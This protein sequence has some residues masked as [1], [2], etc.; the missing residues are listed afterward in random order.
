MRDRHAGGGGVV[1]EATTRP[2]AATCPQA[3]WL[4]QP[5][6]PPVHVDVSFDIPAGGMCAFVGPCGAGKTTVFSLIERFYE[7]ASG[8]VLVDGMD[9]L[10]WAITDLRAAIGYVEQDAPVLSGTLRENLLFGSPDPSDGEL[11][12]VLSIARLDA[13]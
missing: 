3:S 5:E 11:W 7:P 4:Y 1:R 6:L 8:R 12:Q 9:V 10:D 2:R 13:W